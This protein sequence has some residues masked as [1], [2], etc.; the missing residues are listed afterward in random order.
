VRAASA[1]PAATTKN[2]PEFGV[3][4]NCQLEHLLVEHP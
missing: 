4:D 1:P 2:L 3:L